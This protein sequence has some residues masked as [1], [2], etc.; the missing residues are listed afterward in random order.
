MGVV[1]VFVVDDVFCSF[2]QLL[3]W[4]VVVSCYQML[5]VIVIVVVVVGQPESTRVS[6]RASN[7]KCESL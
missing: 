7:Y 6:K 3:L 2:C 1:A 4:S 5:T